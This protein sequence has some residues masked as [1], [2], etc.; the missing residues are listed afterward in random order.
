MSLPVPPHHEPESVGRVFRV[1]YAER[2]S[3]ARDWA[4]VH[5]IA[6]AAED[7][8]RTALLLVDVQNTFCLPEFELFV[9]GRS[10]RGALED[11]ER[12]CAF[13]YRN[14]G[15][16]TQVVTTLDTHTAVQIFHPVF[17]VDGDGGHPEPHTVISREDVESGRWQ[18]N[19]S[20]EDAVRPTPG[21]DRAQ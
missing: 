20:L 12:L 11:N 21:F 7:G 18:V 10:G 9:G 4:E 1:P 3:E 2:A 15:R 16:I 8:T 6:P 5:G 13:L 17:W 14:L 19:P